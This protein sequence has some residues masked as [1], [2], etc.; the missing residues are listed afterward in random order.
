MRIRLKGID[1]FGIARGFG[2]V[3]MS[4]A[5]YGVSLSAAALIE[6]TEAIAQEKSFWTARSAE[7]TAPQARAS[8]AKS[9]GA[10]FWRSAAER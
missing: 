7:T 3:A 5:L 2:V 1:E 8:D 9:R 4:A 6:P 10:S